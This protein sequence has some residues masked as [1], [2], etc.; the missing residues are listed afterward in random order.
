MVFII[1]NFNTILNYVCFWN[2]IRFLM[3]S[4]FIFNKTAFYTAVEKGNIEMIKILLSSDKIDANILNI[5]NA[6][7]F[8]KISTQMF[9]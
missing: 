4:V 5:L 6:I 9:Q 2:F 3:K 8:N 1:N 7:L